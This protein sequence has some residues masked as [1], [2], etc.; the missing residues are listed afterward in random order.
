MSLHDQYDIS[1][2][3][4]ELSDLEVGLVYFVMAT[5]QNTVLLKQ[6]KVHMIFRMLTDTEKEQLDDALVE[7]KQLIEMAQLSSANFCAV[8][9]S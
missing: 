1:N 4:I 3:I 2:E 9:N 7:A 5:K 6:L 8:I